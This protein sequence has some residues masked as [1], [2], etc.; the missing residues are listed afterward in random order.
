MEETPEIAPWERGLE[1][2]D[3]SVV[4]LDTLISLFKES[5]FPSLSEL[6]PPSTETISP[7]WNALPT[8]QVGEI[9]SVEGDARE[10]G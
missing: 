4:D 7:T 5:S 1:E 10:R 3:M 9:V 8:F 6:S 2:L